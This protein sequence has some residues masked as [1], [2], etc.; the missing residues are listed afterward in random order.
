MSRLVLRQQILGQQ[1]LDQQERPDKNDTDDPKRFF[2][3]E[4]RKL[5]NRKPLKSFD[6]ERLD[7]GPQ[8]SGFPY[9]TFGRPFVAEK[10][11]RAFKPWYR[12]LWAFNVKKSKVNRKS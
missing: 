8:P 10:A 2:H 6:A 9:S 5:H 7:A 11:Q 12:G 3:E 1:I 4:S